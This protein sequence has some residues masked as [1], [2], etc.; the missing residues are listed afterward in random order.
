M[1]ISRVVSV[2]FLCTMLFLPT[3]AEAT[4]HFESLLSLDLKQLLSMEI[5]TLNKRPQSFITLPAARYILDRADIERSGAL[6]VPDLL[7]R[8][9]GVFVK[10]LSSQVTTVS[11]RNDLQLFETNLLVLIDNNPF[12]FQANGSTRWDTLPIAV[13]DIE[14]IEVIRGDGGTAW[15]TNSSGGVINII[16]VKADS[17]P[18][19]RL[20]GVAGNQSMARSHAVFTRENLRVAGHWER[21]NGWSGDPSSIRSGYLHGKYE[22]SFSDWKTFLSGRI[23]GHK[24]RD[25]E[26]IY[27][28]GSLNDGSTNSYDLSLSLSRQFGDHSLHIKTFMNNYETDL[29][30][31]EVDDL[32]QRLYDFETRY[33]RVHNNHHQTQFA[34]NYRQYVSEMDAAFHIFQVP[35]YIRD[36]VISFTVDHEIDFS[37]Q[38]FVNLGMRYEDFSLLRDGSFWSFNVRLSKQFS[39]TAVLWGSLTQSYQF[40]TYQYTNIVS[41][42]GFDGINYYFQEN[43]PD[44]EAERN[45]SIE[46]GLRAFFEKDFFLDMSCYYTHKKDGAFPDPALLHQDPISP[47]RYEPY[48]NHIRSWLVGAELLLGWKPDPNLSVEFATTL[49][50]KKMKVQDGIDRGEINDQYAPK[51]KMTLN[52]EY[53]FSPKIEA[54][55]MLLYEPGHNY[56]SADIYDPSES[57]SDHFRADGKVSCAYTHNTKLS[58]G[59]K[60]LFNTEEEYVF[61]YAVAQALDV[62]PSFY[63]KL[64]HH[65]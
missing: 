29:L 30:T 51:L 60:N 58:L 55:L 56:T 47:V 1:M 22:R 2:S 62:D 54:S 57:S 34:F 15:G 33:I 44:L 40:P 23:Y 12:Y 42:L 13:E 25:V 65:W 45:R 8:I 41:L 11:T 39:N 35:D 24:A 32:G 20:S 19:V 3:R 50:Y 9:P 63:L 10:Q 61:P 46:V 31:V 36:S 6:T 28:P 64:Q 53:Q 52:T 5:A 43:N 37:N 18:K 38:F 48:S 17:E 21:D 16:T 26:S 59:F 4:E 49:F 7:V 27:S 14:R